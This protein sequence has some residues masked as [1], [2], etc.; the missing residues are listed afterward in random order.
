MPLRNELS[1]SR[2]SVVASVSKCKET[3]YFR[4]QNVSMSKIRM[5]DF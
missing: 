2:K 3:F 5:G 1:A 4:G